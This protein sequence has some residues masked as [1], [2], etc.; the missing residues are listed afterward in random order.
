M[1]RGERGMHGHRFLNLCIF[2]RSSVT[3]KLTLWNMHLRH[4]PNMTWIY[5]TENAI[6]KKIYRK[7]PIFRTSDGA[8]AD[9]KKVDCNVLH[10]DVLKFQTG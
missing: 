5:D 9:K 8:N 4:P 7:C 1:H 6:M 10:N 2:G 3:L